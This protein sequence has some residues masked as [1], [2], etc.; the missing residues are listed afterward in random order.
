MMEFFNHYSEIIG[1]FLIENLVALGLYGPLLFILNIVIQSFSHVKSKLASNAEGASKSKKTFRSVAVG[2]ILLC[3]VT[4]PLYFVCVHFVLYYLSI[5]NGYLFVLTVIIQLIDFYFIVFPKKAYV[6]DKSGNI[7]LPLITAAFILIVNVY[8]LLSIEYFQK[9]VLIKYSLLLAL[10]IAAFDWYT[11]IKARKSF[12]DSFG[13]KAEAMR[14]LSVSDRPWRSIPFPLLIDVWSISLLA[15]MPFLT[16]VPKGAFNFGPFDIR[17]RFSLRGF[18]SNNMMFIVFLSIAMTLFIFSGFGVDSCFVFVTLFYV[19]QILRQRSIG[20]TK[21]STTI[22]GEEIFQRPNVYD[23]LL[24]RV[25]PEKQTDWM[26]RLYLKKED[27]SYCLFFHN[28]TRLYVRG[29]G[30][31][32]SKVLV[33]KSQHLIV[34]FDQNE[35]KVNVVCEFDFIQALMSPTVIIDVWLANFKIDSY[36][37]A[38]ESDHNWFLSRLQIIVLISDEDFGSV[39]NSA[40]EL[41]DSGLRKYLGDSL[42]VRQNIV[43]S[44]SFESLRQNIQLLEHQYKEADHERVKQLTGRGIYELNTLFR[45]LH[46]SP[47]IPSRFIDLLNVAECMI[48]YLVG[49]LHAERVGDGKVLH[50]SLPFD[51]KAI[52]FGSCTDFLARWKK[53]DAT[54]ETILGLR[55]SALLDVVYDDIENV[56]ALVKYIRI[57]NPGVTAKYSQKPTLLELS[58]WMVTVRNKTRGHGTPSKVDYGFYVCLEKV[59]LFMLA[60]CSKLELSPCYIADVDG[61]KWTFHLSS[62][63]Y[64][65]PVPVVEELQKGVHFNPLLEDEMIERLTANHRRIVSCIP[66]GDEALYLYATEGGQPEWWRCHKHFQV[67]DAI[68]HLLNQRDDKKE[69]W[70]SFSTGRI[71]RP[72]ISEI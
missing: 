25:L 52:A 20:M 29:S 18:H 32:E 63:G 10:I 3:G 43:N 58:W 38:L 13:D 28:Y 45:Q 4:L 56:E 37:G 5:Y 31:V 15:L 47:S 1:S 62:G 36:F 67:K 23:N 61:Q 16:G 21:Y 33:S 9:H 72:E 64:P 34:L 8:A 39:K 41:A 30:I 51:T 17:N 11:N 7:W 6:S 46:E 26:S 35:N 70:I 57:M 50:G 14:V 54:G 24:V 19:Y 44:S 71:M 60:E 59:V 55:I 40:N 48:R 49:F 65:E 27:Y 42:S 53:S 22:V 66:V 68:V 69:S 2:L 12:L